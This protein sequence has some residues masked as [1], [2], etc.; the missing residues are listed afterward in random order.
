LGPSDREPSTS[1]SGSSERLSPESDPERAV[2]A[3]PGEQDPRQTLSD[4]GPS[5][6][7]EGGIVLGDLF[8]GR[9]KRRISGS[10]SVNEAR[11][12]GYA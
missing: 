7:R 11:V 9:I 5:L 1:G 3:T 4:P 2:A 6:E 10:H 8:R 12:A